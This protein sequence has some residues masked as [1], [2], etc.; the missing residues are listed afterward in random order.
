MTGL[1]LSTT[2]L[3]TARRAALAPRAKD[4]DNMMMR[5]SSKEDEEADDQHERPLEGNQPTASQQE[6]G[7]KMEFAVRCDQKI[8]AE[9]LKKGKS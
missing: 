5:R 1:A 2:F 8:K 9:M 6:G 7:R 4:V 3:S